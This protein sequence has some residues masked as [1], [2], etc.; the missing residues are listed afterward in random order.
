M[1]R[2][3]LSI[4]LA[5]CVGCAFGQTADKLMKK[6]KGVKGMQYE[7]ITKKIQNLKEEDDPKIYKAS[8]GVTLAE[9]AS[10]VLPENKAEQ[11]QKDLDALKGFKRI[12]HEKH[13]SN[14]GPFSMLKGTY[15]MFN[16]VQYFA[17]EEGE[18]VTELVARIDADVNVGNL[19]TLIHLKGMIKQEDVPDMIQ[20]EEE[21][22]V[23]VKEEMETGNV[24]IV[25]NGQEYSNLH[26]AE[27]ATEWMKAQ[28]ISWNH[29]NMIVG[30]EAVKEKYP[31]T[32]KKVAIEFSREE[33][34]SE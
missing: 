10:G 31:N 25:I 9:F 19:I 32:D 2:T 26:S 27:E 12:Y 21:T 29:E 17:V 7:N 34:K 24:L 28:G 13:N 6:Y 1:K 20:M 23:N 5:L 15:K 4:A 30:A 11:L 16:N 3:I 18:Y 8:R 33:K 22:D 14:D